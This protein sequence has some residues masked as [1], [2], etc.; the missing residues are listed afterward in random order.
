MKDFVTKTKWLSGK[1]FSFIPG[2][3]AL[4]NVVLTLLDRLTGPSLTDTRLVVCP[5]GLS[6]PMFDTKMLVL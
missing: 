4:Y 6:K 3:K 5:L 1:K 2:F